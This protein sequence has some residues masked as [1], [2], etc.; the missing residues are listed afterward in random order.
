M[1]AGCGIVCMIGSSRER[2]TLSSV[3]SAPSVSCMAASGTDITNARTL[4]SPPHG[5]PSGK[6]N[7]RPT[8]NGI[9]E[10]GKSCWIQD[11]VWQSFGSVHCATA[12]RSEQLGN[13]RIGYAA[14]DEHSRQI[15]IGENRSTEKGG[16]EAARPGERTLGVQCFGPFEVERLLSNMTLRKTSAALAASWRPLRSTPQL[17]LPRHCSV[18]HEPRIVSGTLE[19][20]NPEVPFNARQRHWHSSPCLGA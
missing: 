13:S 1:H 4:L 8:W 15:W 20:P 2:P 9:I 6:R 7:S 10:Q 18:P 17:P 14:K 5:Q 19:T 11:G 16:I 12:W 3:A